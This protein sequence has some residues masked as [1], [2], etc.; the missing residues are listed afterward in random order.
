VTSASG[1]KRSGDVPHDVITP[2]WYD[3]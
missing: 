1:Q 3:R 2:Y